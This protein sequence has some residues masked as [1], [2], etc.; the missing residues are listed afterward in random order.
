MEAI[1][2]PPV[3]M[4]NYADKLKANT[5]EINIDDGEAANQKNNQ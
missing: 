3:M 2:L 5:V 4:V 1:H